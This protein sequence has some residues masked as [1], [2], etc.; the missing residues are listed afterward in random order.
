[1]K[2]GPFLVFVAATWAAARSLPCKTLPASAESA[3]FAETAYNCRE[4]L[5][6]LDLLALLSAPVEDCPPGLRR[7][8]G[9][10]EDECDIA[11]FS[12]VNNDTDARLCGCVAPGG[13][14]LRERGLADLLTSPIRSIVVIPTEVSRKARTV[15]CEALN[16]T[17][18]GPGPGLSVSTVAD[19]LQCAAHGVVYQHCP[20][21][22]AACAS[23]ANSRCVLTADRSACVPGCRAGY[24]WDGGACRRCRRCAPHERQTA[25]CHGAAGGD[26]QCAPCAED[27]MRGTD[28]SACVPCPNGTRRPPH[29][30]RCA[31]SGEDT[32]SALPCPADS[33]WDHRTEQCAPC[34][35]DM[36]RPNIFG[37]A[38][39]RPARA[40]RTCTSPGQVAVDGS[41][42]CDTCEPRS[43]PSANRTACVRCPPGH[44]AEG[45]ACVQC[46]P[47]SYLPGPDAR[48]CA[49]CMLGGGV[50]CAPGRYLDRCARATHARPC[51]CSCRVCDLTFADAN[52]SAGEVVEGGSVC[53]IACRAG[54]R[55][56]E[57]G[58]VWRLAPNATAPS[59]AVAP[60]QFPT[61]GRVV[62]APSTPEWL[63]W[64]MPRLAGAAALDAGA[65]RVYVAEAHAVRCVRDALLRPPA[66]AG[67]FLLAARDRAD[68]TLYACED[69]LAG[70]IAT[71]REYHLEAAA[72]G[73]DA[74][75]KTLYA[76]RLREHVLPAWQH[77]GALAAPD[78]CTY[79]CSDGYVFAVQDTA[80]QA[81]AWQCIPGEGGAR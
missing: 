12:V 37:A 28:D 75:A 4:A 35:L 38:R 54:F 79:R 3:R 49:R 6:A 13:C 66:L 61:D 33:E 29:A 43:I 10:C 59:G 73:D 39:C 21:C 18:R 2:G 76:T 9:R 34:P 80:H 5:A 46:P 1:M 74:A 20:V 69:I 14:A 41:A 30:L 23:D 11:F 53:R 16:C 58:F 70:G 64:G 36:V 67:R 44:L 24:F 25:A 40:G 71:V 68:A 26:T 42:G 62:V 27:T 32:T 77:D 45:D 51:S 48:Q 31:R 81:V 63:A 72:P 47:G 55:H 19:M 8:N 52:A 65:G 78:T 15:P 22:P 7:K 57:R 50:E 56:F 17:A 60:A